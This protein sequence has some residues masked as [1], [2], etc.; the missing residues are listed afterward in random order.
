MTDSKAIFLSYAS[1]DAEAALRLCDALRAAGFTIWFD[2]E[3]L[4]GGEAWDTSIRRQIKACHLFLPVISAR[5]QAREE[6]YFRREW[7]LAVQ[8]TL[9]M[10]EDRTFLLPVVIDATTQPQARVPERFRE[11]QWVNAP[12]GVP[13]DAFIRRLRALLDVV[14]PAPATTKSAPAGAM[15]DVPPRKPM[16]ARREAASATRASRRRWVIGAAVA[17][18]LVGAAISLPGWLA[19]EHARAVLLPQIQEAIAHLSRS[20]TDLLSAALKV[21]EALPGNATLAGLW[22]RIALPYSIETEPSGAEVYW[23]EYDKADATWQRAGVTPLRNVKLPRTILRLEVRK[24]GFQTIEMVAPRYL[25]SI[26][27]D[28]TANLKLDLVGSLPEGMVRIPGGKASMAIVGLE[29]FEGREVPQ[30]LVDRFE[31]TNR[32]FKAFVEAGGYTNPRYWQ[33]PILEGGRVIPFK[34][35][36]AWFN[37]RTGRHGPAS[38][39]AGTFPDGTQDHPVT[40]VS[41]YEAAAY[42]VYAGKSLPTAFQW[43]RIADTAL[44]EFLVP[45]S[46]FDSKSPWPVGS[47]PGISTYG[48]YDIAGNAREW[49]ANASTG[50]AERFIL[51]GGWNDPTYAFN[52]GYSQPALDRGP[53]NGFRCVREI[54][55]ASAPADQHQALAMDA[56]DYSHEQAVDDRTFALYA[57]QFGYD[58]GP[59]DA[60]VE[61]SQEAENWTLERVSVNAAYGKER[62]ILYIYKPRKPTPKLQPVVFFPGSGSIV[63]SR[64]DPKRLGRVE[65]IVKCGRALVWPIYKSTYERQDGRKSDLSDESVDYKDHVIMWSRDLGRTIDYLETRPDMAADKVGFIGISWGGELAPILVAI[66]KRIKAVVLNVGG[67]AMQK[68]L[69]EA[70]PI[71]FLPRVHQPV[72]MLNGRYDMYFPVETSQKPM[73]QRLGSPTADKKIFIYASGHI[74]PSVE[75]TTETL[76]WFDKYLGPVP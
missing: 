75:S 61:S 76:A 29:R 50:T 2:K 30:F 71:N 72:L 19:R 57:R 28:F 8:R 20:D 39:E 1:E 63:E 9:D 22:G 24:A 27:N 40:G 41:W 32:Q 37:D 42:A 23:K 3:E 73:F 55:G 31:V 33:Q 48:V 54:A 38:W 5:T 51:G 26:V 4:R 44:T 15:A 10:A 18:G 64:F 52:D 68:A 35:A 13:G 65:F 66:E 49:M 46:N 59:L 16:F 53:S 67:L 45:Y 36:V 21:E 74:V 11:V 70:D 60:T 7:N 17:L 47:R 69:P 12:D 34:E 25:F 43:S 62:L 14:S 58:H 6:G 56:R